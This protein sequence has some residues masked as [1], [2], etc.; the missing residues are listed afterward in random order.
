MKRFK[1]NPGKTIFAVLSLIVFFVSMFAFAMF[2]PLL[3][4]AGFIGAALFTPSPVIGEIR[5][6][7]GSDV[8]ST[9]HYG[10]FIRKLIKPKNPR[11]T[12]QTAVRNSL[13]S[14]A[15]SWKALTQVKILGWN[16][17]TLNFTKSGR[18]GGKHHLTGEALYIANNRNLAAVSSA[19]ITAPPSAAL[20]NVPG[21]PSMAFSI[22]TGVITATWSE[23][24]TATEKVI[25]RSSGIVSGGRTFNSK[26]KSFLVLTSSDTSP[27]TITTDWTTIFGTAPVAGD[28]VF[29][30]LRMVE[31]VGGFASNYVTHRVV[32][33]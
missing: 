4:G 25:L 5:K 9:N 21:L 6:K 33:S 19:L 27:K 18:L 13:K 29:F 24:I 31:T 1:I 23:T 7:A 10:G 16:N 15:V 17:L 26:Y 8:F 20:A 28:V 11:S 22:A 32:A 14:I 12:A 30:E 3:F 2:S